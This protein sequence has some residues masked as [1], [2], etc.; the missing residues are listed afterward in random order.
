MEQDDEI[1]PDKGL[2]EPPAELD[3]LARQ[4]IGAAIEV[5]R[6]LGPGLPEEV[7]ERAL[8]I[9]LTHRGIEFARQKRIE[10]R[11]KNVVVGVAKIDLLIGGRLVVEI[12]SVEFLAPIHRSQTLTYI[13]MIN[14][15]LGLLINFNV[16]I[17]KDGVRRI[18]QSQR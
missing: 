12:K 13:R 10:I 4:V 15:V 11:Y 14:E 8:M 16:P 9:E 5:H 7:Y 18:V 6:E 3:A 1:P 2:N 17:L